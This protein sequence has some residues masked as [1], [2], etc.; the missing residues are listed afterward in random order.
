[1]VRHSGQSCL[2]LT[3]HLLKMLL[4]VSFAMFYAFC[5]YIWHTSGNLPKTDDTQDCDKVLCVTSLRQISRHSVMLLSQFMLTKADTTAVTF[6][7][8]MS[9]WTYLVKGY[10]HW[11][12]VYKCDS[13]QIYSLESMEFLIQQILS[14]DISEKS[15]NH[16]TFRKL[17]LTGVCHTVIKNINLSYVDSHFLCI[18]HF[19]EN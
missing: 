13:W 1:M 14:C 11:V 19:S 3:F 16:N 7:H 8:L 4:Y 10:H 15:N 18:H 5:S 6:Q 17:L 9:D 2:Q 12:Y